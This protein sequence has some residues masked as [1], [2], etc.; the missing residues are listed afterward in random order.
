MRAASRVPRAGYSLW[1][2]VR[3]GH[4]SKKDNCVLGR[5]DEPEAGREGH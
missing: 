5:G 2:Y 3:A 4:A 1:R